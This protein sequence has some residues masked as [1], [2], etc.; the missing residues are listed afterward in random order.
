MLKIKKCTCSHKEQ[1]RMYGKGNRV[2]TIAEGK[3]S[4]KGRIRC[5]VCERE[6]Q[7]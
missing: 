7:S 3:G 2:F 6:I 1:D 5:T 4:H